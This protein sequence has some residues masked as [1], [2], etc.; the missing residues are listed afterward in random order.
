MLAVA[1]RGLGGD[2][3]ERVR[4]AFTLVYGRPA[5]Q[6]EIDLAV[7]FLSQTNGEGATLSR[8]EQYA[9]VLLSANEFMYVD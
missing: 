6:R 1:G 8:W 9:Q 5:T 4:R 7:S 3:E 2:D